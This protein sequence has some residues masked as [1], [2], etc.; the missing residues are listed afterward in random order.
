MHVPSTPSRTFLQLVLLIHLEIQPFWSSQ[1]SQSQLCP[2]FQLIYCYRLNEYFISKFVCWKLVPNTLLFRCGACG[3]WLSHESGILMNGTSALLKRIQRAPSPLLP[4]RDTMR[5]WLSMNKE[6]DSY[7]I[8]LS[9]ISQP[10]FMDYTTKWNVS[11]S[12]LYFLIEEIWLASTT[13]CLPQPL[14]PHSIKV[15]STGLLLSTMLHEIGVVSSLQ[16]PYSGNRQLSQK[17]FLALCD[18]YTR[19]RS[20]ICGRRFHRGG[21]IR[22]GF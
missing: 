7:Q 14:S 21:D 3:R 1:S 12:Q 19:V 16:M 13:L 4:Y 22:A 15:E 20:F 9:F 8:P 2:T 5:R 17:V 10:A 6:M 11:M 18:K